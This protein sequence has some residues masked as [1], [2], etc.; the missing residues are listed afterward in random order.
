MEFIVKQDAKKDK[1]T[2]FP[3][4]VRVGIC[5]NNFD[6]AYPLGCHE[7]IAYKSIDG[8]IIYGNECI[9]KTEPYSIGDVIGIC[10]RLA[11]PKKHSQPEEVNEGSCVEFYKNG[12]LVY[13]YTSLKQL[14]YCFGVSTFN[15]S[16]IEVS[17]KQEGMFK[18]ANSRHYFA[19]LREPIPYKDMIT[20][21][22]FKV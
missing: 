1:I 9:G 14:F 21:K 16:Q 17:L 19:S 2:K 22:L 7:S 10:M 6:T 20:S 18:I 13:K 8:R 5:V 12:V 3:S 11:P 15:Y 4:A